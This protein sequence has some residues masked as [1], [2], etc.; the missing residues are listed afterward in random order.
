R[1]LPGPRSASRRPTSPGAGPRPTSTPGAD[2]RMRITVTGA[3]GLIG[4]ALVGELLRRGDEVTVLT[5]D[6]ARARRAFAGDGPGTVEAVDWDLLAEPA[7]VGALAGRDAVVH[8]AGENVAQR[9][10]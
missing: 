3:T 10:T 1:P 4:R 9:W 6:T 2:G 8:L 7:P 5:R